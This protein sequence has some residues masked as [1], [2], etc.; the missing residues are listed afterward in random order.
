MEALQKICTKRY[1]CALDFI[2]VFDFVSKF[3]LVKWL[4]LGHDF[5][6]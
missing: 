5:L 1:A 3:G 2:K 4:Y 6:T